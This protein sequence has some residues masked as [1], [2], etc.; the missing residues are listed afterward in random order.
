MCLNQVECDANDKHY[1]GLHQVGVGKYVER[2]ECVVCGKQ[3]D[4]PY[5]SWCDTEWRE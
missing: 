2:F 5:T 1:R 3:F 4:R